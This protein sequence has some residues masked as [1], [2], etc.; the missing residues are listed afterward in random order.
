MRVSSPVT[1]S[2][3][4]TILLHSITSSIHTASPAPTPHSPHTSSPLQRYPRELQV[5]LRDRSRGQDQETLQGNNMLVHGMGH[6]GACSARGAVTGD[7]TVI[8]SCGQ[9]RLSSVL[10]DA[11]HQ[12]M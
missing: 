4:R 12:G 8:S 9:T 3:T 10:K 7:L 1:T 2:P 6:H 5:G 11:H